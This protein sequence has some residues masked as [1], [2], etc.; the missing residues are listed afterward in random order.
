M[1]KGG[2]PSLTTASINNIDP[3][4]MAE[5]KSHQRIV[6]ASNSL[7]S[8]ANWNTAWDQLQKD[9]LTNSHAAVYANEL[10]NNEQSSWKRAFNNSSSFVHSMDE[11]TRTNF[12]AAVSGGFKSIVSGSGGGSIMVVGS[13]G[14][15]VDFKVSEDT[16]RAFARDQSR[17]RSEAIRDTFQDAQGL[18]Y[19]TKMSKQIGATEAYSYLNDARELKNSSTST[20]INIMTG[21]IEDYAINRYG[22]NS[23]ENITAAQNALHDMVTNQGA[24]GKQN[25]DDHVNSYLRRQE[26]VGNT[27]A[28]VHQAMRTNKAMV[29]GQDILKGAVNQAAGNAAGATSGVTG[30]SIAAPPDN[31]NPL[32]DVDGSRTQQDADTL[33]GLNRREEAGKGRIQTTAGGMAKEGVGNTFQGVVDSQGIRPTDEGGYFDPVTGVNAPKPTVVEGATVPDPGP[34]PKGAPSTLKK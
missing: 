23:V 12:K 18:D 16:A 30:E 1:G 3:I 9:S 24:A 33:R 2:K 31:P 27:T 14:E 10:R 13:D 7:G 5:M 28:A 4:K 21:F 15:S 8:S 17:V 6:S 34:V 26:Y 25:F 22:S 11:T 29:D 20:G 32:R 19:L